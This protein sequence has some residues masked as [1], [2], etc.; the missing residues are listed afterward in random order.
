MT[1]DQVDFTINANMHAAFLREV[2]RLQQAVRTVDLTD[3]AAT[4]GL[5]RRYE[6]FSVTLHAHHEGE[7]KFLWPLAL[8]KATPQEAVVLNA[9]T[10]EHE[11]LSAALADLDDGFGQ[12]GTGS[13]TA[14]LS[15]GLDRLRS[16]LVGHCAHEERDAV[17]VVQ[18]YVT[19][20]DLK[21][22][23]AFTREQPDSTM[24]L[25]W[26]CDGATPAQVDSTW[27]MLPGFVRVFVKPMS[28]RKYDKFTQECGV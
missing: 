24:V 14:S 21:A 20:E 5:S 8:A 19:R 12:L 13:D 26:V 10:A 11:S 1:A 22:F 6:F 3:S 27:G 2:D 18:K 25:A 4:S 16:I 17:P 15:A 23:M 28:T 9:M 7:D